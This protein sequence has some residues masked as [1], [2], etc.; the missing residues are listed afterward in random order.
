MKIWAKRWA[1][2]YIKSVP[3][4][5]IYW[6][7]FSDLKVK[8]L[9]WAA[10]HRGSECCLLASLYPLYMSTLPGS[11]SVLWSI[12]LLPLGLHVPG[13]GAPDFRRWW[14]WE[15]HSR[16]LS[17][18]CSFTCS[19][20]S[21][22]PG[23]GTTSNLDL[24]SLTVRAASCCSITRWT[25]LLLCFQPLPPLSHSSPEWNPFLYISKVVLCSWLEH[26]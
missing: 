19:C 12:G 21:C 16:G 2:N 18:G 5:L 25:R 14:R 1:L 26:D 8:L 15:V 10:K 23:L 13:S 3:C 9:W 4:T 22:Q 17:H 7:E 6:N 11:S 24:P 20:S